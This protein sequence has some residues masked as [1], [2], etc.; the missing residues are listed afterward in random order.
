MFNNSKRT[1]AW[2]ICK[3]EQLIYNIISSEVFSASVRIGD[4]KRLAKINPSTA[5]QVQTIE[6]TTRELLLKNERDESFHW[7]FWRETYNNLP[8]NS[9]Q[10]V[11]TVTTQQQCELIRVNVLK[12]KSHLYSE[13]YTRKWK[14]KPSYETTNARR[15]LPSL[16]NQQRP[17]QELLIYWAMDILSSNFRNFEAFCRP[18]YHTLRKWYSA[19]LLNNK[20]DDENDGK[21]RSF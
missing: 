9:P 16:V 11:S 12:Q 17:R 10:N 20:Q 13:Y 8:Y 5:V 19:L 6:V 21:R 18:S 4:R 1:L 2:N 3:F 7:I 15:S 14:S